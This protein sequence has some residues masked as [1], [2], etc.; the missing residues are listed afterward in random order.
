MNIIARMRD[1]FIIELSLE[2]LRIFL[3]TPLGAVVKPCNGESTRKGGVQILHNA[4][5]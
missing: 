1:N 3:L 2:R 4:I 5:V